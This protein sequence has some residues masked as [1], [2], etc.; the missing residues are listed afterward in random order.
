MFQ[1]TVSELYIDRKT[2]E[3]LVLLRELHGDR[4]VPIWISSNGML[5]LAIE[6]SAGKCRPPRPL[7]HD[8]TATVVSRM[9]ARVVKIVVN[10][11]QDHLY[12]ARLFIQ[13]PDRLLEIDTRPSDACVLALKFDA[14]VFVADSV[15]ADHLRLTRESGQ[16][17]EDL[18]KR[19]QQIHPED[20]TRSP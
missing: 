14:P 9:N 11:L 4:V 8:L 18:W 13:S 10:A 3:P 5:A 16:Q 15:V 1:A 6:L 2:G 20:I 12:R 19:L 7:S 17:P